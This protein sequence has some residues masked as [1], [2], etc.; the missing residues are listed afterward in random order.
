MISHHLNNPF[1]SRGI[2]LMN[3]YKL[4]LAHLERLKTNNQDGHFS[5]M[6]DETQP[7]F[8]AF[9]S[10][11]NVSAIETATK[12]AKTV[13]VDTIIVETSNYIRS[14]SNLIAY[15]FPKDSP[16]YQE[17]FL[18]GLKEY[19]RILKKDYDRIVARF[20]AACEKYR[21]TLKDEIPDKMKDFYNAYVEARSQQLQLIGEV[22][23]QSSDT[24]TKWLEL[25]K[26]LYLNLLNLTIMFV[27]RTDRVYD[28]FDF[29]MLPKRNRKKEEPEPPTPES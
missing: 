5:H 3:F 20:L 19:S 10:K 24:Q 7:V 22:K 23:E 16:V 26:Q 14:V 15:H 4:S 1:D 2:S 18:L 11:I 6:I 21:G 17:F 28:F 25:A 9:K 13:S 27:D 29:S 8:D 12:E